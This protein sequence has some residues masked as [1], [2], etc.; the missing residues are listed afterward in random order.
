MQSSQPESV[1][2]LTL[3][4]EMLS[5]RNANEKLGVEQTS[6]VKYIK[7]LDAVAVGESFN[8][9]EDTRSAAV[10]L[11]SLGSDRQ[12]KYA[13]RP[14]RHSEKDTLMSKYLLSKPARKKML[15]QLEP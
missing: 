8:P 10:T 12:C 9:K 4:A 7:K 5:L 14:I 3:D 1:K 11:T 13:E 15:I 2:P 6:C